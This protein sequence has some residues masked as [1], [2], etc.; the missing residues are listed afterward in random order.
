MNYEGRHICLAIGKATRV[1]ETEIAEGSVLI[2]NSFFVDTSSFCDGKSIINLQKLVNLLCTEFVSKNLWSH[3]IMIVSDCLGIESQLAQA[4]ISD[5]PW[6]KQDIS[7]LL[8]ADK[9]ERNSLLFESDI[10][11]GKYTFN[12]EKSSMHL[13]STIERNLSNSIYNLFAQKGYKVLSLDSPG[14]AILAWRT[15]G[16]ENYDENGKVLIHIGEGAAKAYWCINDVPIEEKNWV[17]SESEDIPYQIENYILRDLISLKLRSPKIIIASSVPFDYDDTVHHLK[18]SELNVIDIRQLIKN[19]NDIEYSDILLISCLFKIYNKQNPQLVVKKKLAS[20]ESIM[21]KHK[22][23]YSFSILLIAVSVCSFGVNGYGYVTQRKIIE[24]SPK[25]LE[26]QSAQAALHNIEA[27]NS[28][29]QGLSP[30]L[31]SLVTYACEYPD[32]FI[33]TI[34]TGKMLPQT[35]V[36]SAGQTIAD[37]L[38]T[39]EPTVKEE[40]TSNDN[41]PTLEAPIPTEGGQTSPPEEAPVQPP[42]SPDKIVLRGYCFQAGTVT[43]LF[44]DIQ[45]NSSYAMYTLNGIAKIPNFDLYAFEIEVSD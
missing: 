14:N 34:D 13:L 45:K 38:L 11:L 36:E 4:Q 42:P 16:S 26:V 39:E 10:N 33:A 7:Q 40:T 22:I 25:E 6:Y 29:L 21:K 5:V 3:K 19:P 41:Q 37:S 12:A 43:Q 35:L 44:S 15:L 17:I 1:L 2:H 27:K 9:K 8:R 30:K 24:K 23:L 18:K 28:L 32:I 20:D 31:T